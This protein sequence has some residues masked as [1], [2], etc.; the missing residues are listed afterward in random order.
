MHAEELRALQAPIKERYRGDAEPVR[1]RLDDG[2]ALGRRRSSAQDAVVT[3][4]R[5]EVDDEN[6][7]G[8]RVGLHRY[9]SNGTLAFTI[10]AVVSVL[11]T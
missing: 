2:P 9:D 8:A 4:E 11:M 10:S 5:I 7:R 3:R 1:I 6:A